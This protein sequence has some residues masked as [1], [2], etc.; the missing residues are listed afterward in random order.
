MLFYK[1]PVLNKHTIKGDL[2]AKYKKT[3]QFL[4]KYFRLRHEKHERNFMSQTVN[5]PYYVFCLD[6]L[7]Y[8]TIFQRVWMLLVG[9]A[10]M[11]ERVIR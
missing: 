4:N 7:H 9:L 6:G 3:Q 11:I 1:R 10:R 8:I 5:G 2:H